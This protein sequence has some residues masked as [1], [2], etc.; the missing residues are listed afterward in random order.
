MPASRNDSAYAV[1]TCA[2]R[3]RSSADASLVATTT[4]LFARPSR[5]RARSRNS[6]TSRP[7]SPTSATTTASASTPRAIA[8]EERA[9]PHA[10]SREQTDPLP[11]ADREE[12]VEDANPRRDGSRDRAAFERA[13]GIAVDRDERSG[14]RR[15]SIERTA[16]PVDDPP[17]E[18]RTRAHLERPPRRLHL[19]V[20]ADAGEGAERHP[21]RLPLREPDDL[22]RQRLAAALH[23]HDVAHAHA[24]QREPQ[25]EPRDARARPVGRSVGTPAS[26]ALSASMSTGRSAPLPAA[27]PRAPAGR[28]TPRRSLSSGE[29]LAPAASSPSS[30][31]RSSRAR[32]VS[33][34]GT[35]TCTTTT[36]VPARVRRAG[37]CRCPLSVIHRAGLRPRGQRHGDLLIGLALLERGDLDLAAKRR[38]REAHVTRVTRSA[39][40]RSN[41]GPPLRRSRRR[42]PP[43]VPRSVRGAPARA[44]AAAAPRRSP[45]GTPRRPCAAARPRRAPRTPCTAA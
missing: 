8:P 39:P 43:R 33:V 34:L 9:L 32:A 20:G 22:A 29:A 12:P 40:S 38:F 21:Q 26:F 27:A 19:V 6:P 3:R 31:A 14:D 13:R 36:M 16:E 41:A 25:R 11:L 35:S 10:R 2:A 7:R 28:A 42:D 17:E 44:R 23:V 4:T 18:I 24:R 5:P 30:S 15:P 45:R 37:G 1:A